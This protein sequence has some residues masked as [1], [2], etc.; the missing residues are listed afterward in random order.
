MPLLTGRPQGRA[1][2]AVDDKAV[3]EVGTTGFVMPIP[4][5]KE[6][7]GWRF[8]VDAGRT[9]LRAREIGRNELTV[10]VSPRSP[11]PMPSATMPSSI[12]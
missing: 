5:V 6:A 3:I 12:R 4:L 8:D 11:W 2:A 10:V 7:G 1:E 9:E